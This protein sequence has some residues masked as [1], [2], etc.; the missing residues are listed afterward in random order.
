MCW[1]L[2]LSM[3]FFGR[4]GNQESWNAKNWNQTQGSIKK[5]KERRFWNRNQKFFP[6]LKKNVDPGSKVLLKCKNWK[7]LVVT[8]MQ[9]MVHQWML[10]HLLLN[11]II[12]QEGFVKLSSGAMWTIVP[13][14][15]CLVG[16]LSVF[17]QYPISNLTW[18]EKSWDCVSTPQILP[19]FFLISLPTTNGKWQKFAPKNNRWPKPIALVSW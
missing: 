4:R 14:F 9:W 10:V 1:Y 3:F 6:N 16:F 11:W 12:M 19:D 7:T 8:G 18:M 5:R 17:W 15:R 13:L 2:E